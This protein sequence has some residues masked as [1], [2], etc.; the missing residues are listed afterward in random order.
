MNAD[1]LRRQYLAEHPITQRLVALGISQAQMD[2]V[3]FKRDEGDEFS[4]WRVVGV[5][6]PWLEDR[7]VWCTLR[8]LILDDPA[9]S[10]D[11]RDAWEF[12]TSYF[13][14]IAEEAVRNARKQG[15]VT[16]TERRQLKNRGRNHRI[17]DAHAH[18]LAPKRIASDEHISVSQVNRIIKSMTD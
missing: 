15:T 8:W 7:R 3:R 12:I 5:P 10:R 14:G 18:G 11:R 1:A 13:R 17:R 4:M 16:S 6:W 9:D 2:G